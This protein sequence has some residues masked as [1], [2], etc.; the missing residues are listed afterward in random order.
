MHP[1]TAE[2]CKN[3]QSFQRIDDTVRS[4]LREKA[5]KVIKAWALG[6]TAH[7]IEEILGLESENASIPIGGAQVGQDPIG[8]NSSAA[9]GSQP[10]GGKVWCPDIKWEVIVYMP[11]FQERGWLLN[12]VNPVLVPD[13]WKQCP[14]CL[15]PRPQE[16]SLRE[17]L[18]QVLAD[19]Y[20]NDDR[21]KGIPT[22]RTMADAALTFLKSKGL[23]VL[24]A[25]LLMMPGMG[26]AEDCAKS[27]GNNNWSYNET[28]CRSSCRQANALEEIARKIK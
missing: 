4:W 20:N 13:S 10:Q 1:L 22:C 25:F 15:T 18:S 24:L 14:I 19:A 3:L 26:W 8:G 16:R 2:V 6:T 7:E 17:E 28:N 12:Q 23:I 21:R 27:C 11:N 9:H 5:D